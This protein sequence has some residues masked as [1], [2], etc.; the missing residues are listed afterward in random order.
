MRLGLLHA[1]PLTAAL[2]ASPEISAGFERRGHID[3]YQK[4]QRADTVATLELNSAPTTGY[5]KRA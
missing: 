3:Q 5:E 2:A 1:W 4:L